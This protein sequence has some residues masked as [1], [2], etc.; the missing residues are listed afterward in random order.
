MSLTC[1][2]AVLKNKRQW[3]KNSYVLLVKRNTH[4]S[5]SPQ[6]SIEPGTFRGALHITPLEVSNVTCKFNHWSKQC[7]DFKYGKQK[8]HFLYWKQ[9][10]R[11][12]RE[13]HHKI[14]SLPRAPRGKG[15]PSNRNNKNREIDSG[16]TSALFTSRVN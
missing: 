14:Y 6:S 3:I 4:I 15:T 16:K 7:K 5:V 11:R 2:Y 10:Y 1:I 8:R 9:L 13:C 12:P